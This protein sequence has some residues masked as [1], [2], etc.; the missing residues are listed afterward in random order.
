MAA[1]SPACTRRCACWLTPRGTGPWRR[2][3]AR[4]GCRRRCGRARRRPGD[5]C[6]K[7][8][9]RGGAALAREGGLPSTLWA[10]PEKTG[11]S[12][13]EGRYPVQGPV[14]TKAVGLR[15]GFAGDDFGYAIDLGLPAGGGQT[16]FALDPEIKREKIWSGP[17]LRPAA[18]LTPPPARPLRPTPGD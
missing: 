5:R 15:L 12:V 2:W 16:A 14:R 13:R 3:P 11:R 6:A 18:L 8:G 4:G 1:A 10:G 17:A 7:A 9:T